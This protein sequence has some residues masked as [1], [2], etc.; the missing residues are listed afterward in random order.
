MSLWTQVS[1]PCG[2]RSLTSLGPD[3]LP[4]G[5]RFEFSPV[6]HFNSALSAAY[7]RVPI[8]FAFSPRSQRAVAP[9]VP[10]RAVHKFFVRPMRHQISSQPGLRSENNCFHRRHPAIQRLGNLAIT[11]SLVVAQY[12]RTLVV[13]RQPVEL[14]PHVPLR[15]LAKHLR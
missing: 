4:E 3:L 7:R 14:F 2:I 9:V 5:W 13:I 1:T 12:E 8:V 11:H 15:F 10:C 6:H